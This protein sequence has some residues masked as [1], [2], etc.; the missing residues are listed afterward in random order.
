L[1]PDFF[2]PLVT[3]PMAPMITGMTKHFMFHI[4]R[5]SI[6]KFLYF[7]FFS[8]SCIAFLSDGIATSISKHYLSCFQL[9]CWAYLPE[10]P[11]QFVSLDST[12]LLIF[13]LIYRLR[14]VHYYYYYYH[15]RQN[16]Y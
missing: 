2:G 7:N 14:Y 10:P 5:I 6:I 1:F 4:H 9:L 13:M 16:F 12:V 3:I 11:Y 15:Y 8:N